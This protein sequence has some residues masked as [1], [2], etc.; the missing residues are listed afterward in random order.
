MLIEAKLLLH[1]GKTVRR[2]SRIVDE[3][4]GCGMISLFC[5]AG[6]LRA[7]GTS[8][9][10]AQRCQPAILPSRPRGRDMKAQYEAPN[11]P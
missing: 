3:S 6:T 11:L 1:T 10:V 8:S 7:W 9:T 5:R 4:T 2:H